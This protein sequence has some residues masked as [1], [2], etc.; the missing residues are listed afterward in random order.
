MLSESNVEALPFFWQGENS[1][2]FCVFRSSRC[3][4]WHFIDNNIITLSPHAHTLACDISSSE[5]WDWRIT[6]QALLSRGRVQKVGVGLLLGWA[7]R[8]ARWGGPGSQRSRPK[9]FCLLPR[10]WELIILPDK[11]LFTFP[12]TLWRDDYFLW[13]IETFNFNEAKN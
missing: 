11:S 10:P 3:S 1:Q 7:A 5:R 4:L 8:P 12:V 6:S 2:G 9:L 13:N